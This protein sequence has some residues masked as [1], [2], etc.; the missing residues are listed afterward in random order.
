MHDTIIPYSDLAKHFP[1]KDSQKVVLVGGCFD[2]LH[3]GHIRFLH[4]AKKAGDYLLIALESDAFIRGRKNREP[5][6]DQ[7]QR[8]EIM[9]ALRDV[10]GVILLPDQMNNELYNGLVNTIRPTVIAVTQGDT[11]ME[12]KKRQAKGVNAAVIVV[13]P[14]ISPFSSSNLLNYGTYHKH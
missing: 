14:F 12:N 9:I 11:Q 10:D 3:L 4:E 1:R 2:I 7:E 6:H 13:T 5:V 8:A